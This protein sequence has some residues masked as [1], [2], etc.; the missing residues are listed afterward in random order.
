[1]SLSSSNPQIIFW[2]Y[3][4]LLSLQTNWAS[5][6]D[7]SWHYRWNQQMVQLFVISRKQ[8]ESTLTETSCFGSF[9]EKW[10]QLIA[11][12]RME[13]SCSAALFEPIDSSRPWSLSGMPIWSQTI[14]LSWLWRDIYMSQ[15]ESVVLQGNPASLR[16]VGSDT[17][18]VESQ[19]VTSA[20]QSCSSCVTMA[21]FSLVHSGQAENQPGW[22]SDLKTSPLA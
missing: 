16:A 17:V 7:C 4:R 3:L 10:R 19:W 8:T 2:C 18:S 21:F 1:M 15:A 14:N 5:R 9:I 12:S 11:A 22:W 6:D 20:W 13:K